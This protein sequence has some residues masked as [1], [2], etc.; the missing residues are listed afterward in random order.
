MIKVIKAIRSD[1]L[2][3]PTYAEFKAAFNDRYGRFP[4]GSEV[5]AFWAGNRAEEKRMCP[6]PARSRQ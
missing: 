6:N 3:K 1:I 2:A 5:L 4:V